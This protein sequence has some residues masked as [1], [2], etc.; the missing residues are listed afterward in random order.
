MSNKSPFSLKRFLLHYCKQYPGCAT[1]YLLFGVFWATT[2]PFMSYLLGQLIDTV[3]QAKPLTTSIWVVTAI[4][5]LSLVGIHVLRSFG[6]YANGLCTLFSMPD[7]KA[8]MVNTLFY[9]LGGQSANYFSDNYSGHLSNKIMNAMNSLEP[10]LVCI[11]NII[12]PQVLAI[13]I[14]GLFLFS[15]G[16]YFGLL[17][18][19]W[20]ALLILF[21]YKKAQ[22]GTDKAAKFSEARSTL[23]GKLTDI[24]T[25][26]H[27]VIV[28]ATLAKE[29][30]NLTQTINDNITT[31]RNMQRHLNTLF[32]QHHLAMNFLYYSQLALLLFSFQHHLVTVGTFV[33]VFN[34]VVALTSITNRLGEALLE[35]MKQSGQLKEGMQLLEDNYAIQEH[36]N[37]TALVIQNARIHFSNITFYH[38]EHPTAL[39]HEF[40]LTIEAGQKVGIVG[41]SGSGKTTLLQL[42]LRLYDLES[43]SITIDN[44][45]ISGVTLNSLRQ[46]IALVPQ[47]LTLFHRSLLENLSYGSE[48]S[49]HDHIIDIAKKTHCHD[50]IT[51]LPDQYQAKTGEQG[52]KLSG[53]Q[54]QRIAIARAILKDSPIVLL[55]EATSALD[56]ITEQQIQTSLVDLLHNKTALVVAHR[57]STL[58]HLDRIIVLK[59]GKIIEDGHHEQLLKQQGHYTSLWKNQT[60]GFIN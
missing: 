53:G 12:F 57:L 24:L 50:F 27:S 3:T 55:D 56:T 41:A 4:P 15:A 22:Q 19:A 47:H 39:F 49:D 29:S 48:C 1:F 59:D 38:R 36:P 25:N 28:N 26:I 23:T 35:F 40:S 31:D 6:Y 32:L 17:F 52:I 44:Q 11:F 54:R 46:Q 58:T 21:S 45:P 51:Q 14:A 18:W 42:L 13:V 20:A 33:F 10:V 9:Y 16:P 30:A 60:D 8:R 7:A 34:T 37:A 2:L 43:G 5:A